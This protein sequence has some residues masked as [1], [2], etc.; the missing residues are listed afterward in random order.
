[1]DVER[2]A[3]SPSA[4]ALYTGT[5]RMFSASGFREVGRTY[6]SR[7]IMRREFRAGSR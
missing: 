7:P 5:V 6:P 4:A 2:L 1:M 3:A